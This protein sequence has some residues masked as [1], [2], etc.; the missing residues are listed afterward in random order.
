MKINVRIKKSNSM[1]WRHFENDKLINTTDESTHKFQPSTRKELFENEVAWFGISFISSTYGHK[2]LSKLAINRDLKRCANQWFADNIKGD[3][4]AVH[5]RG[6][7]LIK[8]K[9]T[10]YRHRYRIDL[11]PY[12]TYLKGVIGDQYNIF[13]CS[14]QAQFIDKMHIAFPGKVFQEILNALMVS[15]PYIDKI[16]IGLNN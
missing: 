13:A 16:L 2:I 10:R 4:V 14:D 8:K 3:W 1:I 7:D 15:L 5:Y 12:I 9:E 11:D 6:T